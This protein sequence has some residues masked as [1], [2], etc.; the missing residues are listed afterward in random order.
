M[1]EGGDGGGDEEQ[2][3]RERV[4]AQ[5]PVDLQLAGNDPWKERHAAVLM[6]KADIGEGQPRQQHGGEKKDRGDELGGTRAGG[7]RFER[8]WL[9]ARGLGKP[10]RPLTGAEPARTCPP[11]PAPPAHFPPRP[12]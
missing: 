1:N 2:D 7:R 10:K 12:P 5:A 11:P 3:R 6:A 8:L 9:G 4:D